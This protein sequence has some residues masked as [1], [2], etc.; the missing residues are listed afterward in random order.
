[1]YDLSRWWPVVVTM[2]CDVNIGQV[3]I[4]INQVEIGVQHQMWLDVGNTGTL[5]VYEKMNTAKY[6]FTVPSEMQPSAI[7]VTLEKLQITAI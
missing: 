1:M 3:L 6:H 4:N 7:K 5:E 2:S